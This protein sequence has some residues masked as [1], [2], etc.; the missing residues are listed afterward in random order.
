[1]LTRQAK[2]RMGAAFAALAFLLLF[3]GVGLGA[4]YVIGATIRDGLR[5]EDWVR[6]KAR[7]R[8]VDAGTVTYDYEWQG[9]KY[10][11][12]RAGTF[13]LG[14]NSDVDDWDDRMEAA[15]VAA[16]QGE[17]PLMVYVNPED[18]SESMVNNE[19]RWKLLAVCLPFA[20]GFGGGG[21]AAVFFI[22]R[23]ALPRPKPGSWRSG[24]T[25]AGVPWLKPRTREAL[26]QWAV[27]I[28]WNGVAIPI[29]LVAIP[30]LWAS[31]EWF[32][33]VLLAIFPLIGLLIL[34]SA[35]GSTLAA[36]REGLFNSSAARAT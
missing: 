18:P 28:V 35:L 3:G 22:G 17:R 10:A 14:G 32:P 29:A 19:I 24:R 30:G 34:W 21:L 13:V 1:M 26:W 6:V 33:I 7:V 31:G 25:S 11:G 5:A 23:N 36:F 27:G 15:I 16:Q 12:D 2:E 8:H 4:S 20:L 9:R